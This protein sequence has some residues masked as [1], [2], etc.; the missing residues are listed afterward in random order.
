MSK[1]YVI[2]VALML[3]FQSTS[4]QNDTILIDFGNTPTPGVWNNI[5]NPVDGQIN[6]MINTSGMSSG[7]NILVFDAFNNINTNGTQNPDPSL[8]FPATATGDSFFGNVA[9]FGGQVQL[10]GGVELSGLNPEKIYSI[11]VFAS[12]EAS[13]NRETQYL[14]EGLS[15]E[16]LY[17]QTA[18]NSSEVVTSTLQPTAEGVIRVT[19]STGPNNNN[20]SGFYYLGVMRVVYEHEDVILPAVLNLVSPNGGEFW[21]INKTPSIIWE[22]ENVAEV[23][24]EYSTNNGSS[25]SSIATVPAFNKEYVWTIPEMPSQEC[26]VRIS[27]GE[28]SDESTA[29]FEI[30]SDTLSC[31]IVV[32]GSSTAEGVGASPADSAWVKR[33]KKEI[34]QQNTRY[35]VINLAKGG[36]TT[37]H[38]LPTG[39][40]IPPGVFVTVDPARNITRAL[41]Y[42]PFAIIINMPSNDVANFYPNSGQLDNYALLQS[43]ALENGVSAWI[44]TTQP[45]NFGTQVQLQSQITMKDSILSIYG[46][47]AIDLWTGFAEPNGF[48][49][50]AFNTGDGVHLNNAGHR[51]IFER[52][53]AKDIHKIDCSSLSVPEPRNTS[54]KVFARFYPNPF[55]NHISIEFETTSAG[56]IN[57]QFVD[58][59]GRNLGNVAEKVSNS[60]K[61]LLQLTPDLAIE[62]GKQVIFCII[63]VKDSSGLNQGS[64]TLIRSSE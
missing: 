20:A 36:Y 28:E 62:T 60:G 16:T 51:L 33:Y 46:D 63:S 22:S 15:S 24:I 58:A 64:Y 12:R 1:F 19:A 8:G 57:L 34:F 53:L 23:F 13:D 61:H 6:N 9:E 41:S 5:S 48:I 29:V 50:P 56:E 45:R 54:E 47:Y 18:S 52:V 59:M 31:R 42:N 26:L 39:T 49:T 17:L 35:E 10:T 38:I 44:C 21:Q 40:T 14:F 7:K 2:I 37:Y 25:W 55:T 43:T 3:I 32:L 27:A 4:A 30:S 11:S